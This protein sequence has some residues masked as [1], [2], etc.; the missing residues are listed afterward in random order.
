MANTFPKRIACIGEYI[1]PENPDT[2]VRMSVVVV[3][4]FYKRDKILESLDFWAKDFDSE[5]EMFDEVDKYLG[6]IQGS[7]LYVIH[8]DKPV[9]L[10]QE[11]PGVYKS[12]AVFFKDYL[13]HLKSKEA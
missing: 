8:T 4:L 12:L 2:L 10:Q 5:G 1:V 3:D 9:L 6:K 11:R 7:D 13:R